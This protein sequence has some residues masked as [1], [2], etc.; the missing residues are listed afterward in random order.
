MGII[1]AIPLLFAMIMTIPVSK[2]INNNKFIEISSASVLTGLIGAAFI[3]PLSPDNVNTKIALNLRLYLAIFLLGTSYVVMLQATKVWS[4]KLYPKDNKGQYEILFAISYSLIPM[5]FGSNVSEFIIKNTG[6]STFNEL[7][8]RYEYIP[9]GNIFLI[10]AIISTFSLIPI[11][12]TK[13]YI[14]KHSVNTE[15]TQ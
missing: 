2:H 12:M 4:K 9:N 10:G 6:V 5:I 15:I 3:F 1:E 8:S 7:T 13:R 14:N 11:F